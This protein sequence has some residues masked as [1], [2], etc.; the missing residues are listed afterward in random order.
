MK[1]GGQNCRPY[2]DFASD[3]SMETSDFI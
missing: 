3:M 1:T 2:D